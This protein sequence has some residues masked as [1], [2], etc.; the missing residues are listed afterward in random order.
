MQQ[1][2]RTTNPQNNSNLTSS[3]SQENLETLGLTYDM[4]S[5]GRFDIKTISAVIEEEKNTDII[6]TFRFYLIHI[7]QPFPFQPYINALKIIQG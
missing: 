1:Q 4:T 5:S 3:V 6:Y 2:N 7:I